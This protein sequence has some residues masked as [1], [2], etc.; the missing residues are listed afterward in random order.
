MQTR[1]LGHALR[2]MERHAEI[3]DP[4]QEI[5]QVGA[6][7]VRDPANPPARGLVSED[8][9]SSRMAIDQGFFA[10]AGMNVNLIPCGPN[11]HDSLV[12]LS[13][14]RV[15]IG[16]A[17]WPPFVEALNKGND[18]VLVGVRFQNSPLGIIS[19]PSYPVNSARDL[20]GLRMLAQTGVASDMVRTAMLFAD[21]DPDSVTLLPAGFSPE[22]LLVCDGVGLTQV[23]DLMPT[24]LDW[25]RLDRPPEVTGRSLMPTLN[26]DTPVR[27]TAIHGYFGGACNVTDGRYTYLKHPEDLN[28]DDLLEFTVMP[29]RT[30]A[31]HGRDC[32]C[33]SERQA[34][35]WRARV[36]CALDCK[37]PWPADGTG[38]RLPRPPLGRRA[39]PV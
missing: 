19:L 12:E 36:L 34:G 7:G 20:V 32:L 27:D 30:C 4:N 33:N 9:V 15:D 29:M 6:A 26:G 16:I 18:F 14:G 5:R 39:R 23:T 13:A 24:F 1:T 37:G 25:F 11:A 31:T 17:A 21:L 3:T 38:R 8:V 35:H 10:E 28:A 22:A 2:R